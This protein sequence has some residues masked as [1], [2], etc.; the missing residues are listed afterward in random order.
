MRFE[1][2]TI[3]VTGGGGGIGGATCRRF[4]GEGARVA[5]FD[6][7]PD[8][9]RAV[10][11]AIVASGGRATAFT[12]DITDRTSVDAAI[13]AA[14]AQLGPIGVLVNNAGWDVFTKRSHAPTCRC[15][16]STCSPR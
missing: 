9:A 15:R 5:V 14:E 1:G 10:A 16:T 6:I 8:A 13:A 11:D 2:K 3:V 12:C 7:N 4:A